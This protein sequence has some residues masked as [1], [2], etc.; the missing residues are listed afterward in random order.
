MQP[1][2]TPTRPS[3][4]AAG[5]GARAADAGLLAEIAAG[6][7]ADGDMGA[8]LQRFLEPIVRLAGASAGAVRVL[9]EA[10]DRLVLV[11]S[12]GLP[13]AASGAEHAVDRHCGYC[14]AATASRALVWAPDIEDCNKRIGADFFGSDCRRMLAVPL[15]HRGRVLGV[16][17]LF[18]AA[19]V[20]PTAQI[21]GVL[22][23]IGELIGLAMNNAALEAE[24]LRARLMHER[25]AMAAEVHDSIAQ[26]LTFV[27]M[28]L[29]LLHDALHAH[30][31]ARSLR[32]LGDVR[33]AIGEAHLKLRE[34]IAQLRTRIDPRGLDSALQGLAARFR[35]RSGIELIY[36]NAAA[37]L[38][39]PAEV[40]TDIFHIAQEALAN[41]EKHSAARRSW[42][43]FDTAPGGFE[44]RIEDDGVGPAT[45]DEQTDDGSHFGLGIM[46]ERAQRLGG[47]LTV[48]ARPA[49]GTRVRLAF[50]AAGAR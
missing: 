2:T 24:T 47:E 33:E 41:I 3:P 4:P 25:Q 14:G 18:Y 22:K 15:Q 29:P 12:I 48:G 46:S 34:I 6:L 44:I 40:E 26:T 43:T 11:S 17:N 9:S 13:G 49:G 5:A 39:L 27:K 10:G 31:D 1:D 35:Q 30:D 50:P 23:T 32:Y 45:N 38:K 20:E 28:R 19:G 16:Y 21:R 36:R 42:F 7:S 37:G 8:L